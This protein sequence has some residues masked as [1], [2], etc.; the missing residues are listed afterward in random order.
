MK[1]TKEDF[2]TTSTKQLVCPYCGEEQEDAREAENLGEAENFTCYNCCRD[3]VY[4]TET[5]LL[6]T[7]EDMGEHFKERLEQEK[8]WLSTI[9]KDLETSDWSERED[10]KKRV[11]I[12]LARC[13]KRIR[14]YEERLKDYEVQKFQEILNKEDSEDF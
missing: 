2:D 4:S 6:Y 12:N 5:Y 11:E 14:T 13:E 8:H 1:T 10:A 9:I 7:S 3:F